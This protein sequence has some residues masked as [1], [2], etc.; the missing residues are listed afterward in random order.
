MLVPRERER[1]IYVYIEA[2]LYPMEASKLAAFPHFSPVF[3]T[4]VSCR[5]K[6]KEEKGGLPQTERMASLKVERPV[7]SQPASSGQPKKEPSKA[8]E[9]PAKATASRPGPK[10]AEQKP[11]EP[12]K[13]AKSG[14]PAARN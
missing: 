5:R 6:S 14:K 4:L 8:S 2:E 3:Q 11:R 7:G 9:G 10:K 13:K 12:K 1:E